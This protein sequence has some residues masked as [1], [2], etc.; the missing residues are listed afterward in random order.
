M[1]KLAIKFAL[2][3]MAKIPYPVQDFMAGVD[4]TGTNTFRLASKYKDKHRIHRSIGDIGGMIG[5]T[6]MG[7]A[8][9]AGVIALT[10]LAMKRKN[11]TLSS[12]FMTAAKGSLDILRPGKLFKHIKAVPH[13]MKYR[14]KAVDVLKQSK[15]I[16]SKADKASGMWS[17]IQSGGKAPKGSDERKFLLSGGERLKKFRSSQSELEAME[18]NISNRFYG[19]KSVS[20]GVGRTMTALTTIPAAIASGVLNTSSAHMQY[21]AALKAKKERS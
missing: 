3:K 14:N 10:A 18:K 6:A 5:G 21:G 1:N 20:S 15:N 7:A 8:L 19:G 17:R 11:P 4:P 16:S 9:P 2:Q 12:E 13:I